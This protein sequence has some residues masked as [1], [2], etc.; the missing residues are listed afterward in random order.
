MM[1]AWRAIRS[2]LSTRWVPQTRL[3]EG[4]PTDSCRT[5]G[6][7]GWFQSSSLLCGVGKLCDLVCRGSLSRSQSSSASS[8]ILQ[9]RSL[10]VLQP[11]DMDA[12]QK[13]H[14]N[15]LC[16]LLQV[17]P[18]QEVEV[19]T[20]LRSM[21]RSLGDFLLPQPVQVCQHLRN[22]TISGGVE[23][24]RL[25]RIWSHSAWLRILVVTVVSKA[26]HPSL[27][28]AGKLKP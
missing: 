28:H 17:F 7:N 24:R 11:K 2:L 4:L 8:Q 9:R 22:K 15:N 12:M 21:L 27:N 25:P 19:S 6:R 23:M 14:R 20:H 18:S 1:R 5:H 13:M 16:F 3:H 10:Q 26:E